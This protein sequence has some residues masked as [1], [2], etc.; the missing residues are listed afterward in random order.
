VW[1]RLNGHGT[2]QRMKKEHEMKWANAAWFAEWLRLAR[3]Q[4]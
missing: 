1:N 3:Q 2:L 4:A